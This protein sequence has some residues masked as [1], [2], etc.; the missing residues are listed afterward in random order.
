MTAA[1]TAPAPSEGGGLKL[2]S[3]YTILFVLIVI[4]ALAT[5]IIP[6]GAYDTDSVSYSGTD[7][8]SVHLGVLLADDRQPKARPAPGDAGLDLLELRYY[9]PKGF[10]YGSTLVAVQAPGSQARDRAVPGFG[11]PWAVAE[12]TAKA[13]T[14][15]KRKAY[16]VADMELLRIE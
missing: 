2:P 7:V 12:P 9:T 1:A 13:K 16:A 14:M 10:F 15:V 3:A 11:E 8:K 6:A 5:W 4:T